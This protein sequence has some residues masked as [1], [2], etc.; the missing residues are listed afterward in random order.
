MLPFPPQ[1]DAPNNIVVHE[2]DNKQPILFSF[3]S[4]AFFGKK[5]ATV[6][7]EDSEWSSKFSLDVVGNSGSVLC[8]GHERNYEVRKGINPLDG[9]MKI[10][11]RYI[12][13]ICDF[14]IRKNKLLKFPS[15]KPF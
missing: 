8:K 11:Q 12:W 7:V 4:K 9:K 10:G 2:E 6:K 15:S 3:K 14:S 5:K 1:G 13:V